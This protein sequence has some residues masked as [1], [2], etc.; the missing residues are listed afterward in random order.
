VRRSGARS[1][2]CRAE[3]AG[4]GRSAAERGD[5]AIQNLSADNP[6]GTPL[7]FVGATSPGVTVSVEQHFDPGT[8]VI[9]CLMPDMSKD[10]TPHA[11]EGMITSFTVS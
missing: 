1:T 2:D 10:G 3:R 6:F 8:Y 9:A 5:E 7:E 11:M 4:A